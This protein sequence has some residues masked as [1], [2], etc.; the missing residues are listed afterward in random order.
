MLLIT[1]LAQE[2]QGYSK[3]H[4]VEFKGVDVSG[5]QF[6]PPQG[7]FPPPLYE[8]QTLVT[9]FADEAERDL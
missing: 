2:R 4:R 6:D 9:K 1:W 5:Q 7:L 3:E 8:L